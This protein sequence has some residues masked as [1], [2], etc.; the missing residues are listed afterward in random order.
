MPVFSIFCRLTWT[1]VMLCLPLVSLK[2]QELHA[3]DSFWTNVQ[4]L[5]GRSY[6]ASE[7]KAPEGD[8]TFLGKEIVVHVRICA[9][10]NMIMHL[11]VG[12][13]RSRTWILSKTSEGILLKHD[14]R[15]PDGAEDAITQYG[16][17]TTNRGSASRQFF[18]A[19][20]ETTDMIPAAA[21]NVW[22]FEIIPEKTLTYHLIRIGTD[23]V[24]SIA[25][26]LSHPVEHPPLP[27][28]W[29]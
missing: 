28:G 16:G 12:D 11:H 15:H 25:F 13:N 18:P 22:W 29:Q 2:A 21:G 6:R 8:T 17:W 3:Q 1:L 27:W 14:H 23:R 4:A 7:V 24:F 26:D 20:E 5:C 9:G 10:N 19:D